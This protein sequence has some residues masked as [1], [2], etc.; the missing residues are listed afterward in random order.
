MHLSRTVANEALAVIDPGLDPDQ[1]SD[2]NI[3]PGLDPDQRSDLNIDP[4]LDRG[5]R[6][7]LNIDPGLDLDQRSDLN[8]DLALDPDQRSDLNIALALDL[9]PTLAL[10]RRRKPSHIAAR[11]RTRTRSANDRVHPGKLTTNTIEH[12]VRVDANTPSTTNGH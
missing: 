12:R 3:E 2:L 4:G 11:I 9:R 1:R 8:I 7:D 10:Q 6:S 5:Q